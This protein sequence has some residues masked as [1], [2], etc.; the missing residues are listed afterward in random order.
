MTTVLLL[1]PIQVFFPVLAAAECFD[2]THFHSLA[3]QFGVS[4][5]AMAIRLEELKLLR[6]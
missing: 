3:K 1:A 4:V 6:R 2:G 5:E